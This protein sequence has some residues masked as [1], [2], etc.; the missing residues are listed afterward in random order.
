MNKTKAEIDRDP[1]WLEAL[2]KSEKHHRPIQTEEDYQDCFYS[3]FGCACCG[4]FG[5][6]GRNN[7]HCDLCFLDDRLITKCCAEEV[8][9]VGIARTDGDF[10][11]FHQ[12]Q[13]ALYNRIRNER[14]RV[15]HIQTWK[16]EVGK[17]AWWDGIVFNGKGHKTI[18]KTEIPQLVTVKALWYVELDWWIV[19]LSA[20]NT[21]CVFGSQL[22]KPPDEPEGKVEEPITNVA[23]CPTVKKPRTTVT[24]WGVSPIDKSVD[25]TYSADGWFRSIYYHD[26]IPDIDRVIAETLKQGALA[27]KVECTEEFSFHNGQTCDGT[28]IWKPCLPTLM[29]GGWEWKEYRA[30]YV[31][32]EKSYDSDIEAAIVS[33]MEKQRELTTQKPVPLISRCKDCRYVATRG[34]DNPCNKCV[35]LGHGKRS[36][37]EPKQTASVGKNIIVGDDGQHYELG[38]SGGEYKQPDLFHVGQIVVVINEREIP[39]RI[40]EY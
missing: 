11:V 38:T 2:R 13:T 7:L 10:P 9:R 32:T 20:G 4:Y 34:Y 33:Y 31:G 12:T 22:S 21:W 30:W 6:T 14:I 19:Q 36:Y 23:E 17:K 24:V 1:L 37:F 16:P 3:F 27:I 40:I 8:E 35:C 28:Y 5:T 39:Y 15:E 25:T 26:D 29:W 18:Y